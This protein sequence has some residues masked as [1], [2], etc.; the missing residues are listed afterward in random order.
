MFVSKKKKMYPNGKFLGSMIFAY[1]SEDDEKE[2]ENKQTIP[3]VYD[4]P[5]GHATSTINNS[6]AAGLATLG[7]SAAGGM[8][9]AAAAVAVVAPTTASGPAGLAATGLAAGGGFVVGGLSAGAGAYAT[10]VAY[11]CAGCHVGSD[12]DNYVMAPKKDD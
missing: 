6:D 12:G 2:E 5:V 8:K 3:N 1:G 7:A 4:N 11:Q 10:A 9:G